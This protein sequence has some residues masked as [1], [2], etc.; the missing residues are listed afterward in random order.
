M[1][2]FVTVPRSVDQATQH[3]DQTGLVSN[4]VSAHLDSFGT[5]FRRVE[6]VGAVSLFKTLV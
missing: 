1:E 2:H 4:D 5:T 6:V 3:V